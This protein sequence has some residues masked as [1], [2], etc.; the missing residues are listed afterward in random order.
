MTNESSKSGKNW[1]KLIW[2]ILFI[3]II[4][5]VYFLWNNY[6]ETKKMEECVQKADLDYSLNRANEC[7]RLGKETEGGEYNCILPPETI[8]KFEKIKNDQIDS[9][10]KQYR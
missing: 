1:L 5:G 9:C 10:S 7:K 2:I 8:E 4:I 3:L 6:I